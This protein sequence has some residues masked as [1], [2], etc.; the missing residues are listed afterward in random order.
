MAAK[1]ILRVAM[2]HP[3]CVDGAVLPEAGVRLDIRVEMPLDA[4][5][6]GVSSTGVRVVEPVT[7][8]IPAGYPWRSPRVHLRDDFPRTF[9]HLLPTA[10]EAPPR[11]CLVEGDQDEFFLQFGLVE[12]GIFHL[13]EQA[14]VWLRKAAIDHLIDPRQGWEP[15]MRRGLSDVLMLDAETARTA[16]PKSGGFRTWKAEFVRR[17]G[18]A[19]ALNAGATTWITSDGSA[20]PLSRTDN[21]LFLVSPEVRDV[22]KGSTVVG[23]IAP[24]KPARGGDQISDRY[25]PEDVT[26]LGDLRRR[27]KDFGCERGLELFLANLERCFAGFHLPAPIPVGVVLCVRRPFTLTGSTSA[28]ELL[29]YVVEIRP[30]PGRTSLFP[31]GDSE[32]VAPAIHY[33]TL[34]PG[35]LRTL[36]GVP[37]RPSVAVLGAGSVGSKLAMHAARAGQ[38]VSAIS[39]ASWLRPHNMARHAMGGE[40]IG[41]DKSEALANELRALQQAPSTFTGDIA[42]GLRDP[43]RRASIIPAGTKAVINATASLSV[44]EALIHAMKPRDRIR[45]FEAALFGRGRVGYLLADGKD[46]NPNHGDLMAELYATLENPEV[47]ALLFDPGSGLAEVQIGQGCGSLTMTIDDAQLSMMTAGIAKEINRATD[48]AAPDGTIVLGTS[49]AESSS[50]RWTRQTVPPFETVSIG[51]SG[52]WELRISARVAKQIRDEAR[53]YPGVETG[54]LM[55]GL[56]SERLKTVT[57]VDLLDAPADSTRSAG[58]FV[59]GTQGLHRSIEERHLKSG[60]TLFDVGTWHSHLADQGP[61]K[62]DWDTA[63]ELALGRAPPSV[64]LIVTPKRFH[65]LIARGA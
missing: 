62:T 25:L 45:L 51:G 33:Q 8:I 47:A 7:F 30:F 5:D 60:Q 35:L 58:M 55:I 65:A 64:L 15:M 1:H 41:S 34:T 36:S 17:G 12:Y 2:S 13:V 9:A 27:A 57:V 61:S 37:E 48:E 29:P 19:S 49:D 21:T 54:G 20:V 46:H 6:D 14:A 43:A 39:D 24:D 44:R 50:M 10:P 4:K 42:F 52:G 18:H 38:S 32:P 59:L 53:R 23:I 40:H 31:E 28:I 16:A 63:A 22:T 56:S 11:P 3:E 26:T